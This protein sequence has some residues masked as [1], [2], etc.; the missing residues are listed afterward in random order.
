MA[1]LDTEKYPCKY[2]QCGENQLQQM[3]TP[4]PIDPY[5]RAIAKISQKLGRYDHHQKQKLRI[6]HE[7]CTAKAL[8][9]WQRNHRL[10]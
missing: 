2:N 4:A 10:L 8:A 1:S 6:Q 9:A 5:T 7:C 3:A